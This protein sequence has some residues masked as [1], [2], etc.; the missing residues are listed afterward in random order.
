MTGRSYVFIIINRF[1]R[2]VIIDVPINFQ[3]MDN[4]LNNVVNIY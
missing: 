4:M 2:G 3:E 1:V